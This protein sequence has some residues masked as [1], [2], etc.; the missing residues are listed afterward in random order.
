MRLFVVF[1]LMAVFFFSDSASARLPIAGLLTEDFGIL[2][3]SDFD[4]EGQFSNTSHFPNDGFEHH[5]LCLKPEKT[6]LKCE[7]ALWDE[8]FK[9]F[10]G[11]M[12]FEVRAGGK[13]YEFGT[14][15]NW[16]MNFC[17]ETV[18]EIRAVMKGQKAVC[19]FANFISEKGNSSEWIIDRVKSKRGAWSW[20]AREER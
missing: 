6:L 17:R 16:S 4:E 18:S 12:I 1:S 13:N 3:L 15:R 8:S 2:K 14:R 19:F 7:R 20:F 9:W 10:Y 5:W 11:T